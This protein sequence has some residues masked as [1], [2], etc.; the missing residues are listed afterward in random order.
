[1]LDLI[2][3]FYSNPKNSRAGI[4]HPTEELVVIIVDKYHRELVL[5]AID[6]TDSF[7][8]LLANN[9]LLDTNKPNDLEVDR[10]PP[11]RF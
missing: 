3:Y 4:A 5:L 2:M 6:S 7:S 11:D 8:V 1:M 10:S 9:Q